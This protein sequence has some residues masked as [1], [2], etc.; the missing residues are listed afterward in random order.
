MITKTRPVILVG[1][2]MISVTHWMPSIARLSSLKLVGVID[3]DEGARNRAKETIPG[4]WTAARIDG[5]PDVDR[6]EM[7]AVV[8]TPDH[9]PVI[10][11][12]GENGFRKFLVEKP[13]VARD[14]EVDE[15]ERYAREKNLVIYSIDHY[16]PKFLP[17]EFTLGRLP[18]DDPRVKFLE[19]RGDHRSEEIPG[20]LGVVEGVTYTNIEAGDLGIPTLDNR[21]WLEHDPELGGMLRDLGTHA[22]GPLIRVG[23]LSPK[24]DIMDIGLAKFNSTRDGFEP[25]K[26]KTDIEMWIRALMISNGITANVTFGKAPFPGK[27]RSLAVRA[28]QGVFFAGLARGQSSVLMTNDGRVTRI[29]LTKPESDLVLEEAIAFFSGQL[30]K[31]FDGN[32]HASLGALRLN[33]RL[34]AKYLESI[35]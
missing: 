14:A 7:I 12:L 25:V 18:S 21:P 26:K 30:P 11:E 2:G 23:L 1:A 24:A 27:E 8:A 22:F 19:F 10:R 5:I 15:L 13:L 32:L 20:L 34:R 29:S 16:Y 9:F 33:Q 6:D 4:I 3:P 28:K 17:L 35:K 31:S